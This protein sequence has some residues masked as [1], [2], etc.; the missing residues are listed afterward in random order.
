LLSK[1]RISAPSVSDGR[2]MMES[3]DRPGTVSCRTCRHYQ[4]T[5]DPAS[6]YGCR[7]HGFKSRQNPSIVVDESSG[8]QCQL[9]EKKPAGN[10]SSRQ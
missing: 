3:V 5:W 9:Y 8:L 2:G 6:P 1:S 7:A 4:V 10:R